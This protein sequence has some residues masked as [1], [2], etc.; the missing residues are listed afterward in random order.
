MH[1]FIRI[2]FRLDFVSIRFPQKN[3]KFV[4]K[5]YLEGPRPKTPF[6]IFEIFS[7]KY[8]NAQGKRSIC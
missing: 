4:G 8:S 6:T 3:S 5:I 7:I 2:E 1:F